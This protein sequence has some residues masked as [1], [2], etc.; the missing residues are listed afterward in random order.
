MWHIF[1]SH[2]KLWSICGGQLTYQEFDLAF[3]WCPQN[4]LAA[5]I[6]AHSMLKI[7]D[8]S[9]WRIQYSQDSTASHH[10]LKYD[11]LVPWGFLNGHCTF[12][13]DQRQ[14]WKVN[15]KPL[16]LCNNS[17]GKWMLE[18]STPNPTIAAGVMGQ[19]YVESTWHDLRW[20]SSVSLAKGAGQKK[21][22]S[23]CDI[24]GLSKVVPQM[25]LVWPLCFFW[26]T[27]V[28]LFGRTTFTNDE[29]VLPRH[30]SWKCSHPGAPMVLEPSMENRQRSECW[31]VGRYWES[32]QSVLQLFFAVLI[33]SCRDLYFILGFFLGKPS[34]TELIQCFFPGEATMAWMIFVF[35]PWRQ[36]LDHL[37]ELEE[38]QLCYVANGRPPARDGIWW[39]W[40]KR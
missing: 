16:N 17:C 7:D 23:L 26:G 8:E 11:I 3:F 2:V 4:S 36:Q 10:C 34:T 9:M 5:K 13:G 12:L 18:T 15:C 32:L 14:T 29:N 30:W 25:T 40:V 21:Q 20:N 37:L 35:F 38:L 22:G 27:R 19:S 28:A 31:G 33:F 1:N 39:W 6:M 24:S